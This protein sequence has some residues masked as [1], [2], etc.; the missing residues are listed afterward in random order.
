MGLPY[1]VIDLD[2]VLADVTHRLHHISGGSTNWERFFEG[3]EAD[4]LYPEGL[5]LSRELAQAHRLV[6]LSGRPERYRGPTE[7]WL[8]TH[9]V[10]PGDVLLRG[11]RD[12]RPARV[13]KLEVLRRLS[14]E[15]PVAVVVDDDP[16]VCRSA[17]EAGFAVF[18]ATWSRQSEDLFDAQE[19]QGRT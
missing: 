13:V 4:P 2:G 3:M 16:E 18:E 5:A 11:D 9:D 8:A 1:A 17:R 7:R 14:D 6:F 19:R 15:A 10:P 12:R